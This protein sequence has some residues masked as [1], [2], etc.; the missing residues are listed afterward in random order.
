M[1][2]FCLFP[3]GVWFFSRIIEAYVCERDSNT[4]VFDWIKHFMNI[5]SSWCIIEEKEEIF[6]FLLYDLHMEKEN[7]FDRN[8]EL[9]QTK[10]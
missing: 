2:T 9:I 3:V 1:Y 10:L 4:C 6:G 8:L 5:I 7:I